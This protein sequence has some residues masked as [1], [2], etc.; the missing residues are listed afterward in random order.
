MSDAP[1]RTYACEDGYRVTLHI[2]PPA[3]EDR[4]AVGVLSETTTLDL[5]PRHAASLR[6]AL[7]CAVEDGDAERPP[8]PGIEAPWLDHGGR[9]LRIPEDHFA[10]FFGCSF[11]FA[12]PVTRLAVAK[13]GRDLDGVGIHLRDADGVNLFASM[14]LGQAKVLR[15]M[16]AAAIDEASP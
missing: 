4:Y 14:G 11:V 12:E 15:D 6:D 16:L 8:L 5:S 13:L 3:D 7:A 10:S 9:P 2:L 1:F